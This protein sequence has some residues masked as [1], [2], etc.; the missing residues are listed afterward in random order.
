[1]NIQQ[2]SSPE[3]PDQ[4]HTPHA[5][6]AVIEP[7]AANPSVILPAAISEPAATKRPTLLESFYHWV[8]SRS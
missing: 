5:S 2:K 1:M 6:N 3:A 4:S 7:P 8:M